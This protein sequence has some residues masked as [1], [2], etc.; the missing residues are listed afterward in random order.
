[1]TV[2][3]VRLIRHVTDATTWGV[4]RNVGSKSRVAAPCGPG[5]WHMASGCCWKA[6]ATGATLIYNP[7]CVAERILGSAARASRTTERD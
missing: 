3:T 4:N 6:G 7:F 5:H 2:S 1:M